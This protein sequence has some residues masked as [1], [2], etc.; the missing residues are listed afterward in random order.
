MKI[1]AFFKHFLGSSEQNFRL[2]IKYYK[3][4]IKKFLFRAFRSYF[5]S[6]QKAVKSR[7]EWKI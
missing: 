5:F 6:E 3:S 7:S 2:D 1:P 4:E